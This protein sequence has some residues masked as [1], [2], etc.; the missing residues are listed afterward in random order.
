MFII[1]FI[2]KVEDMLGLYYNCVQTCAFK[3]ACK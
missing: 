2:L 3:C 1:L